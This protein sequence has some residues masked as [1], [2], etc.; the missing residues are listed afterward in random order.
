MGSV[1]SPLRDSGS[2]FGIVS[3]VFIA[4]YE[5][6]ICSEIITVVACLD[7]NSESRNGLSMAE[8]P[9]HGLQSM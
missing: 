7:L 4:P 9:L 6:E 1:R 3:I 5:P 2:L 8:L